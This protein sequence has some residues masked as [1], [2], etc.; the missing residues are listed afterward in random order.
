MGTIAGTEV[1]VAAA[2]TIIVVVVIKAPSFFFAAGGGV[3]M[4]LVKRYKG[5]DL[6][7]YRC[8][9]VG[10]PGIHQGCLLFGAIF[11]LAAAA[12]S[13]VIVRWQ[14]QKIFRH[15]AQGPFILFGIFGNG[16]KPGP[17]GR[18]FGLINWIFKTRKNIKFNYKMSKIADE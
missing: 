15:G 10:V 18:I 16:T 3:M 8:H 12:I 5:L 11:I 13:I 1:V 17:V 2:S 4:M 14:K 7:Q 9:S 6:T